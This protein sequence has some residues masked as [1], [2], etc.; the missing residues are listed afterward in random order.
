MKRILIFTTLFLA[1]SVNAYATEPRPFG[2]ILGKTTKSEAIS[3][4]KKE[5]GEVVKSGYRIIKGNIVNP[6]VKGIFFKNL[7]LNNLTVA[8]LWFYKGILFEITYVFPLSMSKEEFYVLLNK[9]KSKYGQPHK[10][11]KPYLSNGIAVWKFNNIEV[12]LIAPWVSWSMYLTYTHIPL[13]KQ[14]ELSDRSIFEKE[15][16]K[17]NRGI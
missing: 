9:L 2:L 5:G 16:S 17:P 10:Y 11:V 4:L 7:P 15:T 8:K 13:N 12:K 14:A 1:I 3:I 6:F